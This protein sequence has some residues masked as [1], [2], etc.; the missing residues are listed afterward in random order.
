MIRNGEVRVNSCRSTPNYKLVKNEEIRIP[1]LRGLEI[2]S[3]ECNDFN[4]NLDK[5]ADSIEI[6]CEKFGIIVVN[7]P[8]GISVHGGSGVGYGV[9][10]AM[11]YLKNNPNLKLAHR[12]DKA[13]SGLLLITSRRSSLIGIQNQLKQGSVKKTYIAISHHNLKVKDVP[14]RIEKPLLRTF[15][16]KGERFVKI[17][18][19]GQFALTK[20]KII[21]TINSIKFGVLSLIECYPITGRTHQIRVHLSSVG[22]PIVGDNKYGL[23]YDVEANQL[24]KKRMYLH[25][26]K[27]SFKNPELAG[28][29]RFCASLPNSFR[30]LVQVFPD[31]KNFKEDD[32]SKRGSFFKKI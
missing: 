14:S 15:D 31:N 10:E 2:S 29:L 7:K 20:I 4:L 11:K 3:F 13:T 32:E 21:K 23:N 8:D 27:I 28:K 25:S 16:A 19:A 22:L 24:L 18:N 26:W 5:I 1:P 12:L 30:E 6:I 9:I 17:D